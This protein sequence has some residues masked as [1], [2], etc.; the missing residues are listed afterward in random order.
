MTA[1]QP[2]QSYALV[3]AHAVR[4]SYLTKLGRL[5]Y[6]CATKTHLD[7]TAAMLVQDCFA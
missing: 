6:R 7:R 4:F 1:G 3:A 2:P 5:C